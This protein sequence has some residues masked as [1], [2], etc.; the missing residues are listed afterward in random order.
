MAPYTGLSDSDEEEDELLSAQTNHNVAPPSLGLVAQGRGAAD[1]DA[2]AAEAARRR[3]YVVDTNVMLDKNYY[4]DR[5][6]FMEAIQDPGEVDPKSRDQQLIHHPKMKAMANKMFDKLKAAKFPDMPA[7]KTRVSP[8]IV[9]AI[10]F[11]RKL[12]SVSSVYPE[13]QKYSADGREVYIIHNSREFFGY[14]QILTEIHYH[15]SIGKKKKQKDRSPAD[16]IRV[17]AVML[18]PENQ[19]AVSMMLSGSRSMRAQSD[20]SVDPNLA[21][22]MD[23]V[24]QFK[25]ATF[26]VELPEE[27]DPDDVVGIDPNDLDFA[28]DDRDAKWF[29][30]TWKLYLKKK[31]KEAIRKWD[32]ET[33][34]GSHDAHEFSNFCNRDRWLVWVYLMDMKAGF[35]LFQFAK[36]QPPVHV[37]CEPGSELC[38]HLF[39]DDG[40]GVD[41]AANSND[42]GG[43]FGE[44]VTPS[45]SASSSRKR[46]HDSLTKTRRD[47]EERQSLVGSVLE[48]AATWYKK[49]DADTESFGSLFSQAVEAHNNLKTLEQSIAYMSPQTK[50]KLMEAATN[51]M[52]KIHEKMLAKTNQD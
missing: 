22:A 45:R 4:I 33:G 1:D 14:N 47:F 17:A 35:L 40:G 7:N 18:A 52:K 19:K 12:V 25:D 49:K 10:N 48:A 51:E 28:R 29:L 8:I 27:I 32:T 9:N 16:A 5:D 26:E 39:N 37:G 24:D 2:V 43:G 41:T 20:Q 31:Y 13:F 6:V 44:Y 36:G 15:F 21:W 11:K 34:G 30:D 23:A 50:T 46:S 38:R 42:D 3:E